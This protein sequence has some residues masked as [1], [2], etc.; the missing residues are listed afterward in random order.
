MDRNRGRYSHFLGDR[1]ADYASFGVGLF[2]PVCEAELDLLEEFF[3]SRDTPVALESSPFI[4]PSLLALLKS[5][6][7]RL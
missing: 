2:G 7:Y 5:R 4:H 6:P 1:L 3:F